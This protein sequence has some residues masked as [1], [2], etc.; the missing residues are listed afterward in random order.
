MKS[1]LAGWC[2][3]RKM[4]RRE[5]TKVHS[6]PPAWLRLSVV[7]VFCLLFVDVGSKQKTPIA[8][9]CLWNQ[10][11][12]YLTSPAWLVCP[13]LLLFLV[14]VDIGSKQTC[15]SLLQHGNKLS[16]KDPINAIRLSLCY[17]LRLIFSIWSFVCLSRPVVNILFL[18]GG[19]GIR[20]CVPRAV[21]TKHFLY[22][23]RLSH[24]SVTCDGEN[25][26]HDTNG[27][28]ALAAIKLFPL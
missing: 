5:E 1:T 10:T 26:K 9:C 24:T 7:V 11:K 4:F 17:F 19:L 22:S 23:V 28:K 21:F 18:L 6:T 2:R 13:L 15:I 12:V 3:R 25:R 20:L 16:A 8:F 27:I 14:F